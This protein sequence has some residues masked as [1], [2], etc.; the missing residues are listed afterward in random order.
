MNPIPISI[1]QLVLALGFVLFAGIISVIHR[2]GILRDL[3]V[4]TLRCVAQLLL[5]GYALKYIFALNWSWVV[6]GVFLFML[7]SAGFIVRGRVKEKHV[8]YAL[9]LFVTMVLSYFTVAVLVTGVI[10]QADPWWKAE[11]FLPLGG[12]V[13]GNSMNALAL[14][15]DR[16]FSDL[17]AKRDE[18][19]MRLSLGADAREAS[20]AVTRKAMS[21]GMIP[22]VNSMMGA[23]LVFIPGMM[24]GQ[25]LAGADPLEAVRYQIVVML[26][27]VGAATLAAILLVLWVR[28]RCFGPGQ[29][30]VLPV[31]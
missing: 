4:G 13:V 10:V 3:A 6:V 8:R 31:E 16:L 20:S 7:V 11:Y 28:R 27:L 30:L 5:L 26:M 22:I 14:C 12:M 19:E 1:W 25:I 24:T 29:Q 9:P 23:G 15:L 21:A 17:R 2:L 18:I